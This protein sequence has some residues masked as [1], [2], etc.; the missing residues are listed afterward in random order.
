MIYTQ[1]ISYL[2][3]HMFI[4]RE[5]NDFMISEKK[6]ILESRRRQIK[7]NVEPGLH[8]E[9]GSGTLDPALAM[10]MNLKSFL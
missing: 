10:L 9:F 7:G 6:K 4:L 8:E 2:L 3:G 5:T 1:V